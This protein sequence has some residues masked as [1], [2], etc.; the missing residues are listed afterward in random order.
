MQSFDPPN[1][2][3]VG[4]KHRGG[5]EGILTYDFVHRIH[6]DIFGSLLFLIQFFA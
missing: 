6:I 1:I 3:V 4:P 5:N 2:G